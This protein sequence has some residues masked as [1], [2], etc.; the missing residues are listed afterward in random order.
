MKNYAEIKSIDLDIP[1]S[2]ICAN[3]RVLTS[4][5]EQISALY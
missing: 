1:D 3:S 5:D 4:L 2:K